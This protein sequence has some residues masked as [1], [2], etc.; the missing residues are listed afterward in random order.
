MRNALSRLLGIE[1]L[2]GEKEKLIDNKS[3][4]AKV[5][6][7]M[8]FDEYGSYS[9]EGFADIAAQ[10]RTL[11]IMQV[12]S[13]QDYASFKQGSE[14]EAQRI[15]SNT[16]IKIFMKIECGQ[17]A[18]LAVE[19]GCNAYTYLADQIKRKPEGDINQYKDTGQGKLQEFN[20]I[21]PNDLYSQEPG[22]CHIT[23]GDKLWRA[24]SF[25]GDFK[26]CEYFRI[27]SF[28][29]LR[30]PDDRKVIPSLKSESILPSQPPIKSTEKIQ[31]VPKVKKE[32][33]LKSRAKIK[34]IKGEKRKENTVKRVKK[35]SHE[36][37]SH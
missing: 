4:N 12:F 30:N 24:D 7:G 3:F 21:N 32:K 11:N 9:V 29:K 10:A 19:R 2:T 14:I 34:K 20:R 6:F 28:I 25:Y 35:S 23:Y 15:L 13:G 5:P 18:K 26:L 8:F 17:T 1:T 27:N 22:E 37:K 33:A 36:R 16:G 31:A